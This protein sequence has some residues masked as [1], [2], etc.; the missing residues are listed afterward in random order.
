MLA[1]PPQVVE[2]FIGGRVVV[3]FSSDCAGN[4]SSTPAQEPAC[5]SA[6]TS[7][8]RQLNQQALPHMSA[9]TA[10][11]GGS[12]AQIAAR[13]LQ[14]IDNPVDV[15]AKESPRSAPSADSGNKLKMTCPARWREAAVRLYVET[16]FVGVGARVFRAY[17]HQPPP[18]A[19]QFTAAVADVFL[20]FSMGRAKMEEALQTILAAQPKAVEE[21]VVV[22]FLTSDATPSISQLAKVPASS[23]LAPAPAVDSVN[24]LQMT[25]PSRWREAAVRQY[26]ETEFSHVGARVYRAFVHPPAAGGAATS[27]AVAEVYLDF[28]MGRTRLGEAVKAMLSAPPKALDG[29]KGTIIIR[30]GSMVSLHTALSPAYAYPFF[31]FLPTCLPHTPQNK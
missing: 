27:T 21:G 4:A 24:K 17:V 29:D 23:S 28:G 19:S 31:A 11:A 9:W 18:G 7:P 6:I 2:D 13:P 10:A 26:V 1:A 20:D 5:E 30:F 22:H 12:S 8:P 3:Q 16:E 15:V 14:V 25:C